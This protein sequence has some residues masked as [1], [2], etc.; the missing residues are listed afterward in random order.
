M[1]VGDLPPGKAR[2]AVKHR[3]RITHP[4]VSLLGDQAKGGLVSYYPL[5]LGD[6]LQV[7]SDVPDGDPLE[8]VDLTAGEDR[9]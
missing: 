4:A 1:L 8:V 3:E 6:V 7:V 9:G 5:A 2:Y